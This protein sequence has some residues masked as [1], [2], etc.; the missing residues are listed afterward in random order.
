M[1]R[2]IVLYKYAAG[3][4]VLLTKDDFVHF[5][6]FLI[7]QQSSPSRERVQWRVLDRGNGHTKGV[8][9]PF[10]APMRMV[11]APSIIDTCKVSYEAMGD[12]KGLYRICALRR[13]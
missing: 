8:T 1:R 9:R 6:V 11:S 13:A 5:Q 3:G 12:D 7:K 4:A 10:E 2:E